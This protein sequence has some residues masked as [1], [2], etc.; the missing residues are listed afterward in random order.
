MS[1]RPYV[2][3]MDGWWRRDT[4]FKWYMAREVTSF[5]VAVYATILLVTLERLAAGRAAFE[6]W[7]GILASPGMLALH[8]VLLV[9]LAWHG[10]TWF[11]IMPKTIPPVVVAGRRMSPGA[12]TSAG[13]AAALVASA[14]LYAAVRWIAS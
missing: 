6:A 13:I 11:L 8:A 4:Y 1:R 9:A 10:V 5:F 14:A 12:I 7:L 2:R 3:P